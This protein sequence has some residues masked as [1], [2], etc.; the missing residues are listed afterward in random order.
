MSAPI[1]LRA[2]RLSVVVAPELG[3][4]L[5]AFREET[6]S[7]PL[8]WLRPAPPECADILQSACYPLVPFSN[9]I[10]NGRFSWRNRGVCLPAN[11]PPEPHAIHGFAW[12]RPWYVGESAPDRTTLVLRYEDGPWPWP[13]EVRQTITLEPHALSITLT[14]EN[15]AETA[16]PGGLGLHPFFPRGA[17]TRLHADV[18]AIQRSGPERM[19]AVLDDAHPAIA[20]LGMGDGVPE[21]LDNAFYDWR[22]P[23]AVHQGDT[24]RSLNMRA[25][26]LLRHLVIYTPK[27]AAFFCAE[28]VS[29]LTG[30]FAAETVSEA[31]DAG[32]V[33]IPPKETLRATIRLMPSRR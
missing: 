20:A 9:R 23:L 31:R 1:V 2:G 12:Q 21:G 29:H 5:T 13:F 30:A 24:G 15:R 10:A 8:D 33:E 28:P 3:G 7:G 14:L 6:P 17:H 26:P 18:R 22:G 27:G 19:P 25:D 32:L 11:F 16:M 4:A